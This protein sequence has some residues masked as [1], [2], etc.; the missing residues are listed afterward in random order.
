M[1]N[2]KTLQLAARPLAC[3]GVAAALVAVVGCSSAPSTQK[4]LKIPMAT[5]S[6]PS[7]KLIDARPEAARVFQQTDRTTILGDE[8]FEISPPRMVEGRFNA[9]LGERLSG[10]EITL[11]QFD[12]R[13]VAPGF[14]SYPGMPLAAELLGPYLK[15][16][17][18]GYPH[19]ANVSLRGVIDQNEFSGSGSVQFYL[20]SGEAELVEAFDAAINDAVKHLQVRLTNKQ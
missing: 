10:K 13:V 16:P 20:G 11:L 1:R 19:F 14:Q 2:F 8:N 9:E 18:L 17:Q 5:V 15:L 4:K 3:I 6:A 7:F 12:A